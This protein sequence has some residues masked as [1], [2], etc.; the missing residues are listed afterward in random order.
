M[1]QNSP[2]HTYRDIQ[3]NPSP[4]GSYPITIMGRPL[5]L[6]M[7]EN[8]VVYKISP[9]TITTLL[10]YNEAKNLEEMR[11]MSRKPM[12]KAGKGILWIIIGAIAVI[13][14]GFLFLT[15]DMSGMM[16]GFMGGMGV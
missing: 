1:E 2:Y 11:N 6:G 9:R 16:Q 13:F 4:K 5:D 15:T 10:R 8:Y 12:F 7:L 3:L 14:L